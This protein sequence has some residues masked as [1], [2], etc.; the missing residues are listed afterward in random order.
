MTT[1][2]LMEYLMVKSSSPTKMSTIIH[3]NWLYDGLTVHSD[4]LRIPHRISVEL[5]N[6]ATK[7]IWLSSLINLGPG[8][9]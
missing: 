4:V 9:G 1:M 3:G 7:S 2:I 8:P 6:S 5:V